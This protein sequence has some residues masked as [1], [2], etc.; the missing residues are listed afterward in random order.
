MIYIVIGYEKQ[1]NGSFNKEVYGAFS[2][3]KLANECAETITEELEF[4]DHCE[5]EVVMI[6][7]FGYK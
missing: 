4:L 2:C 6:D 7:E 3:E 1:E 5:I